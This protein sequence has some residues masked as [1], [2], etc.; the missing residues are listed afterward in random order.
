[1]V[2]SKEVGWLSSVYVVATLGEVM[3]TT[4]YLNKKAK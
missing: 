4:L 2:F 1:M 3:A